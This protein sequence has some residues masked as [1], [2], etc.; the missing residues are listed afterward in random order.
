MNDDNLNKSDVQNNIQLVF[1]Q[2]LQTET[3]QKNTLRDKYIENSG[4]S[5]SKWQVDVYS[6]VYI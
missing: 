6:I 3:N 4:V 2:I 1:V 5:I